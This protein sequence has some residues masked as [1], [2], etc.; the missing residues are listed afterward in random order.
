MQGNAF[1]NQGRAQADSAPPQ[2]VIQG[3]VSK[4]ALPP[5]FMGSWLVKGDRTKV[6]AASPANQAGFERSF[7]PNTTNVWTI[8]GSAHSGYTIGS[9]SGTEFP[10][11]VE[12][13]AGG[14]AFVRYQHP[15]YSTNAQE[16]IVMTLG[17]GG[18][19]FEGLERVSIVKQGEPQPRCK[20]QYHLIGQRQH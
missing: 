4:V 12:K 14:A 11:Y 16:A 13:L 5:G 8:K 19:T 7:S 6:E 20:V 2:H 3:G 17:N 15:V 1:S 9:D 18:T 10:L